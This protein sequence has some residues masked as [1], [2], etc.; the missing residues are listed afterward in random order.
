MKNIFSRPLK[1]LTF[2]LTLPT[3]FL[4][5]SFCTDGVEIF[6]S[7]YHSTVV[8]TE[9]HVFGFGR[10]MNATNL[11]NDATDDILEPIAII[12]ANGYNY[13]GDML[14]VT[15]STHDTQAFLLSTTGLYVWGDSGANSD[16]ETAII[17]GKSFHEIDLPLG[18]VSADVSFLT[19]TNGGVFL[20][21]NGNVYAKG[22][23]PELMG[24]GSGDLYG[25]FAVEVSAGVKLA[26]IEYLKVHYSGAFAVTSDMKYYTWGIASYLGDGSAKQSLAFATEMTAPFVGALSKIALTGDLGNGVSYFVLNPADTKIYSLGLNTNGQLGVGTTTEA[27]TWDTVKLSAG[28]DLID[29]KDLAGQ[30]HSDHHTSAGA[31]VD[32]YDSNAS[33]DDVFLLWGE[34]SSLMLSDAVALDA[35]QSFPIVPSG[36]RL[37]G[38][39]THPASYARRIALGGHTSMFY[40]PFYEDSRGQVG[41]MCYVGH[42][43]QGSMGDGNAAAESEPQFNCED[44]PWLEATCA[45]IEPIGTISGSVLDSQ[46]NPLVGVVIKIFQGGVEINST[47][48][49]SN[50]SYFFPDV[51]LGDYNITSTNL[52]NYMSLSDVSTDNNA[53]NISLTDDLIPVTVTNDE[54]DAGNDFVDVL[55]WTTGHLYTDIN[56]NNTQ[57]LGEPNLVGIVV[58][59]TDAASNVY[60]VMTGTD[61][62]FTVT[63][64]AVGVASVRY[65]HTPWDDSNRRL[66]S[67]ISHDSTRHGKPRRK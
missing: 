45:A 15:N 51:V 7:A 5:G 14:L 25:W 60:T 41:K 47:V 4:Y 27:L 21:A 57:D 63:D 19:A 43:I 56:N 26:N 20:I 50:G 29:V 32:N 23:K 10:D 24:G 39:L 49:D 22:I 38:N 33:H 53:D 44:T 40:D 8:S 13:T 28:V 58:N 30:D 66:K 54:N 12:P 31:I 2:F 61:G 42:R 46:D 18:I 1:L 37:E 3:S 67:Y 11:D 59:I 36:F 64:L 17:T 48:T 65:C 55:T 52:T 16:P 62:N 34:N 35:N 9:V 6:A